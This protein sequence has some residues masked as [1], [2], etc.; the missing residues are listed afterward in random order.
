MPFRAKL[1]ALR[2]RSYNPDELAQMAE[3]ERRRFGSGYY[4]KV[5]SEDFI[6]ELE[7]DSL[8]DLGE[9]IRQAAE[10]NIPQPIIVT[11]ENADELPLR[12]SFL[13]KRSYV[14]DDE[15]RMFEIIVFGPNDPAAWKEKVDR[16]F[17]ERKVEPASPS[18]RQEFMQKAV[19]RMMGHMEKILMESV[20][21]PPEGLGFAT[22][23]EFQAFNEDNK[24]RFATEKEFDEFY[25]VEMNSRHEKA[26]A[27]RREELVNKP[28]YYASRLASE[29]RDEMTVHCRI[30]GKE[31][32]DVY[33][34]FDYYK[35]FHQMPEHIYSVDNT[36]DDGTHVSFVYQKDADDT[37]D[38]P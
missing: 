9:R 37:E 24:K 22:W 4:E 13:I 33:K 10:A 29:I 26:R 1:T 2:T 35:S 19:K 16:T 38:E 28:P 6:D 25:R 11:M 30:V 8:E 12:H 23:E 20:N 3:E 34:H 36:A 27:K 15:Q 7:S 18:E 21:K 5:L 31:V 17:R 14:R 32:E